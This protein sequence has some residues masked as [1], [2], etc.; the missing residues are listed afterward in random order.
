MNTERAQGRPGTRWPHGG[1]ITEPEFDGLL[2][3]QSELY[4]DVRDALTDEQ[5]ILYVNSNTE[6]LRK[7]ARYYT[8]STGERVIPC[9][10]L[11]C[12][13]KA[14]WRGLIG[15]KVRAH[16][17]TRQVRANTKHRAPQEMP[18]LF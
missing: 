14:Y 16:D 1:T 6:L 18:S 8:T 17:L 2:E 11:G 10:G 13:V 15:N 3:I 4:P 12:R 7:T 9:G 5:A